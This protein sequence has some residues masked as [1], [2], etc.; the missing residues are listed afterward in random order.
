M[1]PFS[2]CQENGPACVGQGGPPLDGDLHRQRV[3]A[4]LVAFRMP[5][6]EPPP[7]P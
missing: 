4:E 3:V 2:Q 1:G 7:H 5:V 6:V